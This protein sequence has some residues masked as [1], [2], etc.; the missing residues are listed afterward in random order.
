MTTIYRTTAPLI[1]ASRSPR[2][3]DFLSTLGLQFRVIPAD[4]DETF[5]AGETFEEHVLRLSVEKARA[6]SV[7]HPDAYILGADTLVAVDNRLLGKPEDPEDAARMLRILSGNTHRVISGFS[8]IREATESIYKQCVE[9]DVT[10]RNIL[11]EEIEAYAATLEP[12]DKAGAY[13]IQGMAMAMVTK[14]EGSYTNVVGLP[15]PEVITALM[16]LGAV[17]VNRQDTTHE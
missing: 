16:E 8:I 4:V 12:L 1:L 15:V 14:I 2:R 3:I 10:M 13:A 11:P 17:V 7:H 5:R 6:V 9:T